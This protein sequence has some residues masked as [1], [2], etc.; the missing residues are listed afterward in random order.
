MRSRVCQSLP[1]A[2]GKAEFGQLKFIH[3][4]VN[5]AD[6]VV[7]IHIVFKT[8]RQKAR[9]VTVN[10][11]NE[12]SHMAPPKQCQIIASSGVFTQPR[13]PYGHSVG[14]R[15]SLHVDIRA[16]RHRR[17]HCPHFKSWHSD[18]GGVCQ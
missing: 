18:F 5:D 2:P 3:K 10:S 8:R 4:G 6:R 9:L 16:V 7:R 15:K 1:A 12:T 14:V 13:P 11:F 17:S